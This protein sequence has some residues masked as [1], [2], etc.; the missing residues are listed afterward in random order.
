MRQALR[1]VPIWVPV[2][3]SVVTVA[4]PASA[5]WP[6]NGNPVCV[7]I[8]VQGSLR[9]IAT[10]HPTSSGMD[11]FLTWEDSRD[12]G[13]TQIDLY[14]RAIVP[15]GDTLVP[16]DGTPFC[17]RTG[18][19]QHVTLGAT[20]GSLLQGG[21][22]LVAA[23]E[24]FR[25]GTGVDVF[26]QAWGSPWTWP[27][28]G[29]PVCR[30]TANHQVPQVAGDGGSGVFVIWQDWRSGSP[31]P[32]GQ[33]LDTAGQR[34]WDTT[35]VA[36]CDSA[37]MQY[38]PRLIESTSGSAILGWLDQRYFGR[39][40]LYLQR[41]DGDGGPQ[42]PVAGLRVATTQART[43]DLRLVPDGAGGVVVAWSEAVGFSGDSRLRAT[44]VTAAGA[45]APDWPDSGVALTPVIR[46][47]GLVD[48]VA[49]A[50]GAI[51]LWR[52]VVGSTITQDPLVNLVAQRLDGAGAV[53]AG[54]GATGATVC[55]TFTLL[56]A[57][58]L[59]PQPDGSV[60]AAWCD[61]RGG[62]SEGHVYAL[63]MMPD[64]SRHPAWPS[65]GAAL[66]TAPGGQSAPV[67]VPQGD[68]AIVAWV[69]Q[70]N[71]ATTQRDVYVQIVNPLGLA[72]VGPA[73]PDTRL[74]LSAPRPNP[75]R[76]T[77]RL[78]LESPGPGPVRAEVLDVRGR[79]VRM[80]AD[81]ERPAG[82]TTL[83]WDGRAQ[84]GRRVAPGLY[85]VH[86]T[87]RF[88]DTTRRVAIVH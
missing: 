62:G 72:D 69:D 81:S 8:G 10:P 31:K 41:I 1:S 54:W 59:A 27:A 58:G 4:G 19:Q 71:D 38:P 21:Q 64:G 70:R 12:L 2:I 47:Q 44:R 32:Y 14:A 57:G 78:E 53:V 77:V 25:S 73:V 49:D 79:S 55:G 28:D 83:L 76:G 52:D 35:G 48:A 22:V 65:N 26:A 18:D 63:R 42:W 23:W 60:I 86:V 56:D 34:L 45:F 46:P 17:T 85:F 51:V 29:A 43:T 74:R 39:T 68:G 87:G 82:R 20:G 24:D 33:R 37:N 7:R 11:L 84:D 66:C 5:N 40:D 9:A 3:L 13:T 50:G 36:L 67:V 30:G 6:P 80:L 61:N 16:S 15:A 75:A 88:G